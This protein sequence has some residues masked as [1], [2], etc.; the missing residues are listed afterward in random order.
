M[1]SYCNAST[2]KVVSGEVIA[3]LEC[4]RDGCFHNTQSEKYSQ[5]VLTFR[6]QMNL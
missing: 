6:K 2:D 4:K 1:A 3:S 5:V